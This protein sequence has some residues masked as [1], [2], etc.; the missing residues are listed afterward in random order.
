M[1]VN[2]AVQI[3]IRIYSN[4]IFG[5][6]VLENRLYKAQG[7]NEIN[8]NKDLPNTITVKL[9]IKQR[10]GH[11]DNDKLTSAEKVRKREE[12]GYWIGK[13]RWK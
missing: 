2:V 11:E 13:F 7:Y 5:T 3:F 6:Y 12:F 4:N 8:L 10:L 9:K 1:L